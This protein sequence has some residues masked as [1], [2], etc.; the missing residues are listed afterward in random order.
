MKGIIV[1]LLE[2]ENNSYV[3]F[4]GWASLW[5]L[6]KEWNAANKEK[7][8]LLVDGIYLPTITKNLLEYYTFVKEQKPKA[9]MISL[10]LSL[11]GFNFVGYDCGYIEFEELVLAE[12]NDGALLFSFIA[13]DFFSSNNKIFF[14][15]Y[16]KELNDYNL[17]KK[18]DCALDYINYR[19]LN[20]NNDNINIETAF[21]DLDMKIV[22]IFLYKNGKT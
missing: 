3:G 12:E 17:F 22:E 14:E 8:I 4:D 9:H 20:K 6:L 2:K 19:A 5:P 11:K 13:N 21:D 1:K 15:K 7:K 10:N 18:Y 16:I